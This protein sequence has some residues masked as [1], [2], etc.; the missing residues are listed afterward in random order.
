METRRTA[1]NFG[2]LASKPLTIRHDFSPEYLGRTLPWVS[3]RTGTCLP[4]ACETTVRP[5]AS[6]ISFSGAFTQVARVF[7]RRS[8]V[9]SSVVIDT[10]P[11]GRCMGQ[12]NVC[13]ILRRTRPALL[14]LPTP[15]YCACF[16]SSGQNPDNRALVLDALSCVFLYKLIE[17]RSK[18]CSTCQRCEVAC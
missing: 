5:F 2:P 8:L 11:F 18:V 15:I 4:C 12:V 16:D 17:T 6:R 13:C 7:I 1:S 10:E 14:R 3:E 9:V